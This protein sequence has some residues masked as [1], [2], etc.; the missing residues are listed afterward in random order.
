MST[1]DRALRILHLSDM[2]LFG[3]DTLHYGVVDTRAAF[4]RVLAR[5]AELDEIDI[6]IA[7]GDLSDDGSAESY[8]RLKADLDGWAAARGAD[9]AYVM[10][11]HDQRTAFETVLGARTGVQFVG[12][13]RLVRLDS[14]VP[15]C[16]Y[17][18]IDQQQLR[19]LADLLSEAA[20]HGTIVVLHHPP[21][22]ASTSLLA[23]LE[24]QQPEQLLAVCTTGD[25]R[26]LLSGHY[27]H[28]LV[29][30]ALGMMV[31]VAPGIAN[32]S[33]A[34]APPEIERATIGAGFALLDVPRTGAPR[35][36]F[37]TAP[38]PSDGEE[39]FRLDSGQI[40]S[41]ARAAGVRR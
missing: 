40:D 3:D 26:M 37:V 22:P 17:G 36:T 34:L 19:W 15:G 20:P 39:I 5:A 4:R 21:V 38:G 1:K 23:T 9:V 32:T 30:E 28:P 24:L 16:G 10:G 8:R 11:N 29:S 14:S 12:G 18:Q 41:I 7:S 13:L 25:V 31:V 33:D 27:H 35:V 2:H 6:V